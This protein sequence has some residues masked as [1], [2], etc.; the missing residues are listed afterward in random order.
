MTNY[1]YKPSALTIKINSDS[2]SSCLKLVFEAHEKGFPVQHPSPDLNPLSLTRDQVLLRKDLSD[3]SKRYE[4]FLVAGDEEKLQCDA[5]KIKPLWTT[6]A[7][8][9]RRKYRQ[10]FD[11]QG[12][13]SLDLIQWSENIKRLPKGSRIVIDSAIGDIPWGLL[14]D[15]E[16]PED[17]S[18]QY[19]NEMLEHFW[20]TKYELEVLPPYPPSCVSWE[21]VL[22][23]NESTRFIITLNRDIKD[24]AARQEFFF[25]GV[26]TQL[27]AAAGG[28]LSPLTLNYQKQEVIA[29]ITKRQE[30]LHLLYFF[31]HHKKA[32]GSWTARGYRNYEDTR[33][34]IQGEDAQVDAAT[35]SLS[36]MRDNERIKGFLFPP[37][38]FLNACESAQVDIG[39]PASFMAYFINMLAA[40]AFIGTEGEIPG[41]F[42]HPFGA[43]FVGEFLEG[44]PIGDIL[45]KARRDFALRYNNPFGLYYTLYGDGNVRLT[46][47]L[48]RGK[49]G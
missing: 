10:L 3:W 49:G 22:N 11:L 1:D 26:A 23:N 7:R 21:R 45:C 36:E 34:I 37:V 29:S 38:V 15:E 24:F 16:V 19:I 17:L 18:D 14:Y 47:P 6:L 42:A 12:R 40:Y 32:G 28:S 9:G 39:D 46:Q 4:C 35:I 48:Q 30:P 43:R 25:K 27:S 31:C 13:N 44:H 20:A 5:E 8:W 2:D 41:A 33:M